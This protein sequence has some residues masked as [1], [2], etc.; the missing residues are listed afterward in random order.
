M[1]GNMIYGWMG[2]DVRPGKAIHR[3]IENIRTAVSGRV[4]CIE[5]D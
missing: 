4:A 5:L 3:L 1:Q 2:A